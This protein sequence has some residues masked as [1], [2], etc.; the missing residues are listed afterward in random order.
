MNSLKR[1]K[2][3]GL[4]AVPI[5]AVG[6]FLALQSSDMDNGKVEIL[7]PQENIVPGNQG[8]GSPSIVPSDRDSNN[9]EY[10]NISFTWEIRDKTD[11]AP[12]GVYS[13]I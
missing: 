7:P 10:R 9:I 11:G 13:E 3:F 4:A 5:L 12:I 2:L 8:P 6:F 1:C